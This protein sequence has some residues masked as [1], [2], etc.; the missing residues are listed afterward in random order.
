MCQSVKSS[1]V[2]MS[3]VFFSLVSTMDMAKS[4]VLINGSFESGSFAPNS[5]N[6]MTLNIGA[7]SMTG[8]TVF[9][10]QIAWIG[11]PNPFYGLSPTS[12]SR[13]L[14]LTDYAFGIPYGGVRQTVSTVPSAIYRLSFDVGA[15][16]GGT[17]KIRVTAG[18]LD[19]EATATPVRPQVHTWTRF[20]S[21]FTAI[22][23]N[24]TISLLGIQA[25]SSNGFLG[26]DNVV[27]ESVQGSA[28]VP[29]PATWTFF[30]V[31]GGLMSRLRCKRL[32]CLPSQWNSL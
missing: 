20:S 2:F 23:S 12:G 22:E 18:D 8:W 1:L 30:L 27:L 13:F 25:D 5:Q 28:A 3:L 24:T 6:T 15:Y 10:D 26:L 31:V 4:A 17:S 11:T 16:W 9:N 14:D 21:L 7:T 32:F 29:E 19:A